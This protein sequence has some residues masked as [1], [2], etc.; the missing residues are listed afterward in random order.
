MKIFIKLD[1][2]KI[3]FY[4]NSDFCDKKEGGMTKFV[5]HFKKKTFEK[6]IENYLL[7]TCI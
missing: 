5:E 4:E 6:F 2:L 1:V 7:K 3:L